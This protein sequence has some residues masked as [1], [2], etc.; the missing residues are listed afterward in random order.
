MDHDPFFA[1]DG[2]IDAARALV[3]STPDAELF[4]YPGS[5]HLFA[6]AGGPDYDEAAAGLLTARVLA[7]LS[8]T[9]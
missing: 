7:F 5:G 4:V 8:A 9:G 6:D 1:G 2:D 3:A